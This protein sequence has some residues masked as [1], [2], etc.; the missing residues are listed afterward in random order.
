[1]IGSAA[2][3]VALGAAADCGDDGND[4]DLPFG[5]TAVVVIVNPVVN[6]GNTVSVPAAYDETVVEGVEVDA[7]P[8][9]R[10]TSDAEGIAVLDQL[11]SGEL[12][13]AFD[14]G[15]SL[16]LSI[17]AAGD[18]LDLA[19]AYDGN[20]VTPFE[21]FPIV[22]G[23][24]GEILEFSS[25]ADPAVVADALSTDGNIVFFENGTFV[26]DL[27]ISGDDVIFFGEGFTDREVVIDG[28]VEVRG[29]GVRI[30][31]FTI[32]GDLEVWGNQFGMAFSVVRGATSINGNSVGF[33]ANHFCGAVS[34]PSSSAALLHNYGMAPLGEPPAGI[35]P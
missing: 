31:G 21:S 16:P 35:C 11:E 23:V 7:Q 28:S 26:G 18:V 9:D 34:V 1:V 10:D 17:L 29:T 30:R 33:L 12:D 27:L 2:L 20:T 6:D 19:V 3:L 15:A 25:D 4:G 22:Y 8:G 24:G 5:D 14:S 13:V 32:T